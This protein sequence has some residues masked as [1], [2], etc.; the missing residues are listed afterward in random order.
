M[1]ISNFN[2]LV[3]TTSLLF[4]LSSTVTAWSADVPAYNVLKPIFTPE[5]PSLLD[6]PDSSQI[7]FTADYSPLLIELK[8]SSQDNYNT[9][10]QK[11]NSQLGIYKH[12]SKCSFFGT[13]IYSDFSGI[14]RDDAL[15]YSFGNVHHNADIV[16]GFLFQARQLSL[17]A[18]I[19][20]MIAEKLEREHW[21]TVTDSFAEYFLKSPWQATCAAR[22]TLNNFSFY[23]EL[24]SGP[25]HCSI[26][27]LSNKGSGS[28]RNFP[29]YLLKRH[30]KA[31]IIGEFPSLMFNLDFK[32]NTYR[33][34]D[35]ITTL[36]EMPQEIA[37]N[38]YQ[39]LGKLHLKM[40]FTD[41][42]SFRIDA[43]IAGGAVASYNFSR[44]RL[45]MFES[46]SLRIRNI[47]LSC[48]MLLPLNFS[49]G[50]AC[51]FADLRL[52]SGYLRLS[53]FSSWSI[54]N[55]I[56]YHF[57]NATLSYFE[58]GAYV[59]RKIYLKSVIDLFPEMTLSY[60]KVDGSYT[61]TH[62][63]VVVLFP[64]YVDPISKVFVNSHI[65]MITPALNVNFHVGKI[66][67]GGSLEQ[68]LPF[69]LKPGQSPDDN[70][71][72]SENGPKNNPR[73]FGGTTFSIKMT[74]YLKSS[75]NNR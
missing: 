73:Y 22:Y 33:T 49:A 28:Y 57:N 61:Y 27:K 34:A 7:T 74:R 39:G 1:L 36:N 64:I 30:I 9:R 41:S 48:G 65:L 4:F 44:D 54:F 13:C 32:A 42:L 66:S 10:I 3:F 16:S 26:T 52:P 40:P 8:D 59:K 45:T 37:I 56:D 15:D 25:V 75:T 31:G 58:L 53:S 38:A 63:E 12:F 20:R 67:I 23:S 21:S 18:A 19:G 55:P 35:M 71:K 62:K 50:L 5:L 43:S 24:F 60:I 46:D 2:R 68:K 70:V 29:I 11:V 51:T 47:S 6:L 72:E 14:V 17:G 69:E